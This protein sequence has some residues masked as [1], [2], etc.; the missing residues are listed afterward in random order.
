MALQNRWVLALLL[1][2]AELIALLFVGLVLQALGHS[3]VAGVFQLFGM[4]LAFTPA[5]A[6]AFPGNVAKSLGSPR[7]FA[8]TTLAIAAILFLAF[9]FIRFTAQG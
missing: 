5:G 6:I 3:T 1:L 9:F 7:A 4:V 2:I 8:L